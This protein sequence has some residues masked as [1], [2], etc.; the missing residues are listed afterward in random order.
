MKLTIQVLPRDAIL[1]AV[2]A[3]DAD[4]GL[5]YQL[6]PD[7]K[8]RPLARA[9]LRLGA[10][11]A[12]DHPLAARRGVSLGDCA[13]YPMII[14]DRS[15]TLGAL[16]A[17]ALERNAVAVDRV[18]ETNAIELL[19]AAV[20]TG[21]AVTFLNEID[22]QTE[23]SRGQLVFLPLPDSQVARQE[24]RL[25]QRARGTLDAAQSVLAE[26]L[27]EVVQALEG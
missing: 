7:P 13:G 9:G 16:M 2:L 4:L 11:V 21:N 8:L 26:H 17:E 10:V 20:L 1:A 18:I 24:L 14:P 19:K 3:G 5:G 22:V 23:R 15:V 6:P 12:P 25:I 27:R